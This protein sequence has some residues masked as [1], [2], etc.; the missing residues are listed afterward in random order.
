MDVKGE[1]K[2]N[3]PWSGRGESRIK[4]TLPAIDSGNPNAA[5]CV[6]VRNHVYKE[7]VLMVWFFCIYFCNNIILTYTV[8]R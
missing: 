8:K 3:Q 5:D 7:F 6:D 4:C 2:L 1:A